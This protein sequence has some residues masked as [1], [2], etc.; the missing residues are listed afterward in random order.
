MPTYVSILRIPQ[1]IWIWRATN[2][3]IYWQG[4]DEELGENLSQCH[5]V[6]TNPTWIDPGA[7]PGLRGERPATN[8]LSHGTAILMFWRTAVYSDIRT[9]L[10]RRDHLNRHCNKRTRHSFSMEYIRIMWMANRMKYS[11]KW[12]WYMQPY[13]PR[14]S[15]EDLMKTQKG[16]TW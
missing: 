3:I 14:I 8:D 13:N 1:M 12:S 10:K 11:C 2:R 15:F 4:N 5:F 9:L 16:L 6:T 7:N